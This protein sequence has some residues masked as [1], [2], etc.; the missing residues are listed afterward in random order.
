ML[1]KVITIVKLN[2][3][4]CMNEQNITKVTLQ[5]AYTKQKDN[6]IWAMGNDIVFVKRQME[7][8]N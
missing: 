6:S 7:H 1:V 5:T 4:V 8:L 3:L 2:A